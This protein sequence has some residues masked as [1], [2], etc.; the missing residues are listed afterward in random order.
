MFEM[1][2]HWWVWA[3][4]WLSATAVEPVLEL[5]HLGDSVGNPDDLA[6]ALLISLVQIAII[7]G[8]FRSLEALA[9]AERWTDRRLTRV[10]RRF[11]LLLILIANNP[12]IL[13]VALTPLAR[14]LGTG[15][16][17]AVGMPFPGLLQFFP[18]I[19][20][21]PYL[22]F[23][24]Y[25]VVYDLS[26]YLM[27]RAQH[28]IP[29]WWALHS[30][31]H[32]QRQ[33]SCWTNERVSW[34]DVILQSLV[35][36]SVGHL[37][38]VDVSQFALL[39]L[40]SQLMQEFSHTNTRLRFGRI[41]E[42]IFVDPPYHRLHHMRVEPARPNL[43]NSNFGQ[44]LTLWD[45]LFGTA[46]YGEPVHP[47]GIGDPTVD[48]DNG[49]GVIAMQWYTLRRFW[50]AFTRLDGWKPQEVSFDAS[51][52]PVPVS[53]LDPRAFTPGAAASRTAA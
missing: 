30:M 47:C 36:A 25:Y 5:L 28:A 33:V 52:R 46:L 17:Q 24:L 12:L 51:Y 26:Y 7:A 29:W 37:M 48:A 38:G 14:W 19:D 50:G 22:A 32:S 6:E 16:E 8:V 39:E 35:L 27:H 20:A 31:H 3:I 4:D 18:N 1:V 2:A 9:P 41:L 21:H 10:D 45:Q 11:T 49:R 53:G 23:G 42:R 15:A 34:L 40:V 43:H 13:F 44:V